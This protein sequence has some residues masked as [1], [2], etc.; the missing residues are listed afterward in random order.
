M[1][2]KIE[3]R[4]STMMQVRRNS[5]AVKNYVYSSKL[6]LYILDCVLSLFVLPF[7]ST[8]FWVSVDYLYLYKIPGTFSK[9]GV[10]CFCALLYIFLH[11]ASKSIYRFVVQ[12][13]YQSKVR[14][15]IAAKTYVYV[16][17]VAGVIVYDGID[18]FTEDTEWANNIWVN[19]FMVVS[20]FSMLFWMKCYVHLAGF[21]NDVDNESTPEEVFLFPFR[22]FEYSVSNLWYSSYLRFLSYKNIAVLI[23][24]AFKKKAEVL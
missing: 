5:V 23:Y 22:I 8:A 1:K 2:E 7:L 17:A 20:G 15:H 10:V 11:T 21:G 16:S 18:S 12:F 14:F 19:I 24:P 3:N 13:S 4:E 6:I 9:I